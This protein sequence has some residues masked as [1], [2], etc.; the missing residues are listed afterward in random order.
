MP[1]LPLPVHI[2]AFIASI[3]PLPQFKYPTWPP[4]TPYSIDKSHKSQST[5]YKTLKI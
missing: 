2:Y 3:C 4:S 5:L 1:L